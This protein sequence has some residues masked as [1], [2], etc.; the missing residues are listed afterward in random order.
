[1]PVA[2][3]G[4]VMNFVVIAFVYR[5]NSRPR[6][7]APANGDRSLEVGR[8]VAIGSASRSDVPRGEPTA[9]CGAR[10]RPSPCL[11][12]A[13]VLHRR[14][15]AIAVIALGAAAVLLLGRVKPEKVYRQIDWGLLLMFVGLF[16][17]VHAFQLHVVSRWGVER[18][19]FLLDHPV[20]LLSAGVGGAVEPG[21]QRAGGAAVRAGPA[22]HARRSRRRRPGWPWR[23]PARSPAT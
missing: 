21:Q 20:D 23:C 14:P 3:L 19:H 9:G 1:M 11:T 18:W 15:A 8:G 10:A 6:R 13:A 12:V 5:S 4:L 17:V 22:G 16:I 7:S 2:L